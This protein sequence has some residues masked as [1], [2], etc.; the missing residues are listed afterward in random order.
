MTNCHHTGGPSTIHRESDND[1]G[2]DARLELFA[3]DACW[4][5]ALPMCQ[6]V[7]GRTESIVRHVSSRSVSEASDGNHLD[8]HYWLHRWHNRQVSAPRPERAVRIYSD[9]NSRD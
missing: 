2:D 7:L 5:A 9:N 3:I 6:A 8:D 4:V 1:S